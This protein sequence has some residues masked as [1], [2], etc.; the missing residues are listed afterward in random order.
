MPCELIVYGFSPLAN[1]I[2]GEWLDFDD[3]DA[4][5]APEPCAEWRRD[6]MANLKRP[7]AVQGVFVRSTIGN[8]GFCCRSRRDDLSD[9]SDSR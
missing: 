2:A 7:Q 9:N 3:I 6:E 4:Q 5:I 1:R 8:R